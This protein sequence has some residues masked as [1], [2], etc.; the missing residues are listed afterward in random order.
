MRAA[1]LQWKRQNTPDDAVMTD[2]TLPLANEV[3]GV[4]RGV[5]SS[6]MF[7]LIIAVVGVCGTLASAIFSQMFSQR[8]K[9]QELKNAESMRRTEQEI[10]EKQR[11]TEQLRGCYVRL[12]AN[13]R[14]Y[15]DAMLAYAYAIKAGSSHEAE[16]AEV[17]A[18]RRAQR[19][20]RAE[21]QMIV[22]DEVLS[23][24]GRVNWKLAIAYRRLK[25]IEG[26]DDPKDRVPHLEEVIDM[27]DQVVQEL[28]RTRLVM[29]QE[30]GITDRSTPY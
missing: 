25:R 30:L 28:A 7:S 10:A 15:R 21:A 16:A 17:A 12:N 9:L 2:G 13:D 3:S 29:R 6:A 14:N 24:E 20:T 26:E 27:L 1:C 18:A 22:S 19:D 5:M 23:I 11:R 4:R 8:A